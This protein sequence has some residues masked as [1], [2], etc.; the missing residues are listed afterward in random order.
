MKRSLEYFRLSGLFGNYFLLFTSEG[1][2][3]YSDECA[4]FALRDGKVDGFLPK[5]TT[6]HMKNHPVYGLQYGFELI[7]KDSSK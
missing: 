7:K 1:E 5:K 6:F 4:T 2:R 3:F